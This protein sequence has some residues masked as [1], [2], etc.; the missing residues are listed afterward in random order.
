M[1]ETVLLVRLRAAL[2]S[3]LPCVEH[4]DINTPTADRIVFLPEQEVRAAT[5]CL[6]RLGMEQDA[7]TLA[8]GW[9]AVDNWIVGP[10]LDECFAQMAADSPGEAQQLR[11]DVGA[12]PSLEKSA[13]SARERRQWKATAVANSLQLAELIRQ[14]CATFLASS[15][16]RTDDIEAE[17]SQLSRAVRADATPPGASKG[18][19]EVLV[20]QYLASHKARAAKGEVSIREIAQETG[21][22]QTSVHLTAAWKT[23]QDKLE[24]K[25]L[26]KRPRKRK[27]QAYTS[28]MDAIAG[29][30]ELAKLI[31]EQKAED[32]GSPFGQ[33]RRG[34]V[35][36][37]K[38]I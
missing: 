17:G 3:L 14:L 21:V 36:I 8:K 2:S 31:R 10:M 34:R 30:A 6:A 27:A 1:S 28:K 9:R 7:M 25:G 32:E 37:Q 5:E 20:R 33:G 24:E 11:E 22:P 29:N 4:L 16:V 26:S 12:F 19:R 13:G 23:L 38:K 35:R 18:E 15:P